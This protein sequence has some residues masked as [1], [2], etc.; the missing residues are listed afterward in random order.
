MVA[1]SLS[2]AV[3]SA[4]GST[5]AELEGYVSRLGVP[6]RDIHCTLMCVLLD[7][8]TGAFAAGHI[9]DG[10]IA[11][12]HPGFGARPAVEPPSTG[13]VGETYLITQDGWERYLA[14]TESSPA[15][16]E[17]IST[18]YLM[19]DGVADDCSHPPPPGVFD[20]WARDIDREV[21]SSAGA[22]TS[23]VRLVRWLA[24]YELPGSW[25]DRTLV[26]LAKVGE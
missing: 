8:R 19:S 4:F 24:N 26:V 6:L 3:R 15:E 5:R 16:A 18:L 25:D 12:L 17:G 9:G 1:P 14:V 22:G 10:L 23:A 21:R 20:R 13:N 11:A 2:A 7:T